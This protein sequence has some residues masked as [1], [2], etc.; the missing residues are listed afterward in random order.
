M[1][2]YLKIGAL[3]LALPTMGHAGGAIPSQTCSGLATTPLVVIAG[4]AF[5]ISGLVTGEVVS[6]TQTSGTAQ[7]G[8][9]RA[10]ATYTFSGTA[11][12]GA[13]T[14][15]GDGSLSPRV[16]LTGSTTFTCAAPATAASTDGNITGQISGNSQTNA[17]SDG[18]SQ[19]AQTRFDNA[20]GTSVNRN[21]LFISTQGAGLNDADWNAWASVEYRKY[22]DAHVGDSFDFVGGLDRFIDTNTMVGLLVGYGRTDLS[23][24]TTTAKQTS[25]AVGPYF[26]RRS[27]G[28][29]IDG[30]L[31][32][33]RPQY[34][35]TA[36]NFTSTRWSIGLSA[37]GDALANAPYI[38]P[39]FDLKAFQ[40][41][42]PA[43]GAI[44]ANKITSYTV[45]LGAKISALQEMGNSGLT[46]HMRVGVDGK[47]TQSTLA[48]T[49]RFAYGRL[50][51]GLSGQVGMGYL[52]VDIDYGKT[53]SDVFDRG[54]EMKWEVSF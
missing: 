48:A 39:Y 17:I 8:V 47:S 21:S 10:S 30:F 35:T 27:E 14:I 5:T 52:T 37:N 12:N 28:M 54:I 41:S 23:D 44:A 2:K 26:A 42:Q 29:L 19:N 16:D 31:T 6:W 38:S 15:T 45:S 18:N 36:G 40:E 32:F 53:R 1:R 51:V 50:G 9:A 3:L 20:T 24:G 11:E 49:D 7:V 34:E 22:S 46:P 33:A 4:S 43:Y 25:I 13:L